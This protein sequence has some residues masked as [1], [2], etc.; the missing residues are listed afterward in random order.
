[1]DD[2]TRFVHKI[3]ESRSN[4]KYADGH[5]EHTDD[6]MSPWGEE[7]RG[8]MTPETVVA[9][10]RLHMGDVAALSFTEPR[11]LADTRIKQEGG[12]GL[13]HVWTPGRETL[14]GK[15]VSG[16]IW[17]RGMPITSN[18]PAFTEEP[19]ITCGGCLA[20]LD[21]EMRKNH[22]GEGHNSD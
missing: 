1:M 6:C 20:K 15:V 8:I 7:S 21:D 5:T 3:Q 16:L 14:C 2:V 19:E 10:H 11:P 12:K 13:V 4:K 18:P 22:G 9:N 17:W